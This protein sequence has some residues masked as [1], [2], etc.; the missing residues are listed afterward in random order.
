MPNIRIIVAESFEIFRKSLGAFLQAHP[1][2]E[3]VADAGT[4]RELLERLKQNKTD[5]VLLD[6]D[7]PVMDGSAILRVIQRRYHEVKVIA[8]SRNS[9]ARKQAVLMS[10]GA[11]SVLNK[12][13]EVNTL[14]EAIRK[15]NKDGYY[16]NTPGTKALLDSVLHNKQ[17]EIN[18]IS[19]N[20]REIEILREVC[21]GRTNKQ[22]AF[23]LH[24]S[25][26]TVDFY[27]TRIYQKVKCNNVAGLL[28][29]ALNNGLFAFS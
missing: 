13:C 6:A 28:K 12:N 25:V 20:Q 9:D 11:H 10:Q 5:L 7:L 19:F 1:K 14:M 16:L 8:L 26:S 17:D 27:K 4:G 18:E 24:L 23:D 2:F 15:V 29:Y 22:I 21:E 3:V